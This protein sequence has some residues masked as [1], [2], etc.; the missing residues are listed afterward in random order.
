MC[1]ESTQI[2]I[3]N[4]K[5]LLQKSID[6]AYNEEPSLFDK[7]GVEQAIVFRIGVYLHELLKKSSSLSS[8]HI[9]CE[10][11]KLGDDPEAINYKKI[12][13]DIIVHERGKQDKNI[14]AV[15]FKGYWNKDSKRDIEKLIALTNQEGGFRYKLGVFVKLGK[16]Q[17]EYNY[18][19]DGQEKK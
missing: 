7:I 2:S 17:A 12:R 4:L 5:T 19:Q 11:N 15:E 14:L 18:F 13:P 16:K 9:D 3:N 8:L 1:E 10:Y 6:K